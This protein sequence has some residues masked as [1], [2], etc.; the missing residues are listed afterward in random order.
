[1]QLKNKKFFITG[2]AGFIG[3]TLTNTLIQKGA[4]VTV[5]DNLS[6]GKKSNLISHKNLKFVKG[7]ICDIKLV[8]KCAKRCEY[9]FHLA[10]MNLKK[11]EINHVKC[12]NTNINGSYNILE[13]ARNNSVK[14]VIVSSSSSIYG[15]SINRPFK[16]SDLPSCENNYAVSKVAM[17]ELC[18]VFYKKYSLHYTILRYLNVYGPG[19]HTTSSYT[20]VINNF[21][22]NLI[23]NKAPEVNGDGK[24][25]LDLIYID[26]VIKANFL[27]ISQK[28]NNEIFNIGS[29]HQTLVI[30]LL[31][32]IQ[33]LYNTNIK[34]KYKNKEIKLIKH[35]NVSTSKAKRV[36]GFKIDYDLN[37]GLKLLTNWYNK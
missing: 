8:H 23:N 19:Q 27:A 36:L 24:N 11:C 25:T 13:A 34:P 21:I 2:G 14:K 22:K 20:N 12:F 16:E 33:K 7:N 15:E 32:K 29:G 18:K 30:D 3:S 5:I 4:Y 6:R 9:I 37:S 35:R 31:N 17:E 28:A 10:S 26:D 1:M